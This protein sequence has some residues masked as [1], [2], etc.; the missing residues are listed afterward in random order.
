MRI[1]I[2]SGHGLRIRG[3]K[4]ILDE[5]DEARKVVRSVAQHLNAI[6]HVAIEFHDNKSTTQA[7][8]LTTIVAFHNTQVRDLDVSVHFNSNGHTENAIGTECLYIT[9]KELAEKVTKSVAAV[10]GLINRG[11]IIRPNLAFLKN[12]RRPAILIEV[13]YVT[14]QVDVQRYRTSFDAICQAIAETI[15]GKTAAEPQA[16]VSIKTPPGFDVKLER[17]E[18]KAKIVLTVTDDIEVVIY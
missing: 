7:A 1:V 4:D 6:G 11:A 10:S 5:V 14:S 3:A 18:G 13:C 8:N 12:T 17:I 9:Q 16:S 2:S 15:T